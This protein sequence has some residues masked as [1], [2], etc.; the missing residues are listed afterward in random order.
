MDVKTK[1]ENYLM[2]S[3]EEC[4]ARENALIAD[5]RKSEAVLAK[6]E[7]NVFGIFKTIFITEVGACRGDEAK[8]KKS[9]AERLEQIPANWH[10]ALAQAEQHG[11]VEKAY[12]EKL[13][14]NV[15]KQ[16]KA[17]LAKM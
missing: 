6:I 17:E 13:K 9:F 16:I 5:E 2:E 8:L 12:I 7:A 14:L 11:D 4:T 1:L 3:I 15:V 10:T